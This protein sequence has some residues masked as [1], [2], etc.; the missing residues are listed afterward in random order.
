[1]IFRLSAALRA[2]VRYLLR[3]TSDGIRG[4][5]VQE[6]ITIVRQVAAGPPP[7]QPD[8]L[9]DNRFPSPGKPP[10]W[11]PVLR[12]QSFRPIGASE[13]AASDRRA[14][15]LNEGSLHDGGGV[16]GFQQ[17]RKIGSILIPNTVE[18]TAVRMTLG[19]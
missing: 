15:H 13:C 4:D 19:N 12:A 8:P 18:P 9:D 2:A 1:L 3:G 10:R 17:R 7:G 16:T 14:L 5:V 11:V 6:I